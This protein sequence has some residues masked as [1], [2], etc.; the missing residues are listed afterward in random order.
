MCVCLYVCF[1]D[2]QAL[3]QQSLS[4]VSDGGIVLSLV[5]LLLQS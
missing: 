3:I 1:A 2:V 5:N 4:A